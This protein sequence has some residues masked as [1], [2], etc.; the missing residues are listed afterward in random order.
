MNTIRRLRAPSAGPDRAIPHQ[1]RIRALTVKLA[2]VLAVLALV[3]VPLLAPGG[4]IASAGGFD[5]KDVPLPRVPE[6][7]HGCRVRFLEQRPRTETGRHRLRNLRMGR[8]ALVHLRPRLR[9]R[10]GPRT[11]RS[12]GHHPGQHI[13]RNRQGIRCC[14]V[15]ARRP[16]KDR[17]SCRRGRNRPS[18]GAVRPDRRL[19]LQRNARRLRNVAGCGH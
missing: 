12:R 4:P 19:N 10:P 8:I 15:L 13:P 16:D 3:L 11:R 17:S 18:D 1:S 2:R 14:S 6:L 5:C 9:Q 7:G